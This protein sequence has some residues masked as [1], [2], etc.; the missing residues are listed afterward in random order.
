MGKRKLEAAIEDVQDKY[1]CS[2]TWEPFLLRPGIP[3]EGLE[4]APVTPGNPRVG[5]RLKEAG[6]A[7]GIDFTGKCDRYPNT[8]RSHALLEYARE[9]YGVEKQNELAEALFQAYFTDGTYLIEKNLVDIAKRI[10]L[11]AKEAQEV[12]TNMEKIEAAHESAKNWSRRGV[13]GVPCFFINGQR[14]FSGAQDKESFIRVF[15]LL[16]RKAE[17][18]QPIAQQPTTSH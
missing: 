6:A 7:V 17:A 18:N 2:V 14:C 10:G 1:D 4:K 15:E 12:V 13:T 5:A 9:K 16:T 8:L 3:D 11:D